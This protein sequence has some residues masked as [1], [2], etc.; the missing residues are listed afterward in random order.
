MGMRGAGI[1][2]PVFS[3]RSKKDLGCGEFLDL[4]PLID[5][6][7]ESGFKLIQ[8]LPINDT[9]MT[10]TEEDGHPYSI[11]SAF[12]L[13]PIYLNIEVMVPEFAEEIHPIVRDLNLPHFNYQGTYL[14]KKEL[15]KLIYEFRGEKDL[16]TKAFKTFFKRNEGELKAYAAFCTLRDKYGTSDFRKWGKYKEYS[17]LLV[18]KVCEENPVEFFYF[19][20]YHL[21]K[22]MRMVVEHAKEQGIILKGDFPMGVHPN[23]VEAWRFNEYFRWHVSM[24][25]PPDFYN[26][27]G[28]NWGFPPYDWDEIKEEGF[29]WLKSR[30]KWMD[31]Y[32]DMIRLDHV[33]GY[34]RLWEVPI[35]QVRG[36]MGTFFPSTGYSEEE[37]SELG[38]TDLKRLTEPY[39]DKL[40]KGLKTQVQVRDKVKDKKERERLYRQLENCLFFEREGSFHPRVDLSSTESFHALTD[41]EQDL[42]LG[43]FEEYYLE[44]Q[45]TLWKEKGMEKL[46]YMKKHTSMD[47]CAEDI[48]VIPSCVGE[49][50]KK[51]D[52]INLHVQRMPKSFDHEFEDPRDFPE[53]CV[54]TPSNHDTATLREWWEESEETRTRYFHTILKHDGTPPQK[55]TPELA[56]EIVQAH[57]N[58]K[59]RWAIFLFQDL[60][61]M[62]DDLRTP[63][64]TAERIN[65]PADPSFKWDWRMHIY[66][67]ELQ[68]AKS[69]SRLLAEM[70]KEGHR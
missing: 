9:S 5:W 21:D 35:E 67:E 70:I 14:A 58:S 42:V 15:L 31:Q 3:L 11:L 19:V 4:I 51:L 66:V 17:E 43:L 65:D 29:F 18:E 32:F 61:A 23:S 55:L 45:E 53:T 12:A 39:G 27:L 49:V 57:L 24:G 59:A 69:H 48:G 41:E 20:Q 10:E 34:F 26:S 44:R 62:S 33:L 6:A 16:S 40:P 64:P 46:K 68:L 25:A 7:K 56:K 28:Q 1:N 50:L 63:N 54:C 36:L 60:F 38:L 2:V 37:L 30:L 52:I 8:I 22:Q 47:I 13:H